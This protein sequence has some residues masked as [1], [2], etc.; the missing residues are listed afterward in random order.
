MFSRCNPDSK[1]EAATEA[2]SGTLF[3]HEPEAARVSH[4]R[5]W[6][7]QQIHEGHSMYAALD[8]AIT[9]AAGDALQACQLPT[10]DAR[11]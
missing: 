3:K 10:A 1:V 7:K 11:D 8:F 5:D 9:K 4:M 2:S 6:A